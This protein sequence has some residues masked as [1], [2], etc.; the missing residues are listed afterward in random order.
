MAP[1]LCKN[2]LNIQS[3]F[4]RKS[5]PRSTD[6]SS[7]EHVAE[8]PR[9]LS[10]IE[11]KKAHEYKREHQN[12]RYSM[13]ADVYSFGECRAVVS[14]LTSVP[15]ILMYELLTHKPPWESELDTNNVL[16]KVASDQRPEVNEALTADTPAGSRLI[17]C[18]YCTTTMCLQC[19]SLRLCFREQAVAW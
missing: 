17:G 6:S 14:F 18:Q 10:P 2:E 4:E 15:G 19:I 16:L 1:E 13:K 5:L 8:V 9:R 7:Q 3:K 11:L 12:V